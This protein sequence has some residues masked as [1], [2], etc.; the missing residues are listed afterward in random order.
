MTTEDQGQQD[1]GK[2]LRAQLEA[3]LAENAALKEQVGTAQSAQ[4]EL[5]FLKAGIDTSEG[6]GKLLAQ[7]YDGDL[8]PEAISTFAEEYGVS[9]SAQRQSTEGDEQQQRMDGLRQQSSPE[10]AGKRMSHTE[11][12]ELSQT[13]PAAAQQVHRDGLVDFPSHIAQNLEANRS[14]VRLGG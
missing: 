8:D 11:W 2:G 6:V 14:A 5:A 1:S 4:K 7:S 9:P 10:G 13:D 12:S 3:A